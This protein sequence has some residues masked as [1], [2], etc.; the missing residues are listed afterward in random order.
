[1][2]NRKKIIGTARYF[3]FEG[4]FWGIESQDG[5]K[6][7]PVNMPEQLKLD[8]AKVKIH[9]EILQ[10]AFSLSMWGESIRIIGFE[11]LT[12]I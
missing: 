11:T 9:A 10:D 2:T 4:G 12:T 5:A 7:T 3:D 1:M 8:G 6:Y